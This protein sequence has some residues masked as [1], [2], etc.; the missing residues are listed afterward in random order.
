MNITPID[1]SDHGRVYLRI[2]RVFLHIMILALPTS[3]FF[4]AILYWPSYSQHIVSQLDF[5]MFK[6][7]FNSTSWPST[8]PPLACDAECLRFQRLLDAWPADKPKAA[9][10]ILLW[11]SSVT[12]CKHSMRLL[13][14]NFN[15][16]YKYPVI[17]FL[18][19]KMTIDTYRQRLRSLTNSS[20]YFQVWFVLSS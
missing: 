19:T 1:Y 18:E 4:S 10:I 5:S 6:T 14:V 13:S 7:T 8:T 9:V 17:I 2:R 12:Y 11:S 16:A 20:L 3:V 15:D